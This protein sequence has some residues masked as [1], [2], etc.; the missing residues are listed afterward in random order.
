MKKSR[1]ILA[2]SMMALLAGCTPAGNNKDV[3]R[4]GKEITKTEYLE[5]YNDIAKRAED[6]NSNVA[7]N[8]KNFNGVMTVINDNSAEEDSN[9]DFMVQKTTFDFDED[10]QYL[11][12]KTNLDYF[13]ADKENPNSFNKDAKPVS[14]S[15]MDEYFYYDAASQCYFNL[16][17]ATDSQDP[18]DEL[19]NYKEGAKSKE[20]DEDFT[21]NMEGAKLTASYKYADPDDPFNGIQNISGIAGEEAADMIDALTQNAKI[22]DARYYSANKNSLAIDMKYEVEIDLIDLM[23]DYLAEALLGSLASIMD[24]STVLGMLKGMFIM[25]ETITKEVV[26]YNEAMYSV[27]QS[28]EGKME[29]SESAATLTSSGSAGALFEGLNFDMKTEADYVFNPGK[30]VVEYPN[31]ADFD[32]EN[33]DE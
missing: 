1:L 13:D 19:F 14:S 8:M 24:P 15:V 9:Y 21:S 18:E 31:L 27:H 3:D 26:F 10:K 32:I 12:S 20:K 33:L 28:A 5:I 16:Q 23:G 22:I 7:K 25:K 6:P 17:A 4:K 2:L 29:V 30:C 11:H